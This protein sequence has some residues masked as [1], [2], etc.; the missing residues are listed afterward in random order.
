MKRTVFHLSITVT[1]CLVGCTQS[2]F[3][4]HALF[5]K[6]AME[7]RVVEQFTDALDEENEPALRRIT[8]SR[9]EEKA[10][11]SEDVLSDLRVLHLPSGKLSVVEVKEQGED[12]REVIVKE[13]SGGKY[14]FHLVRDPV[15]NYWV[16]DDVMVRQRNNGT[17]ITKST[18]EVM[19]LLV[20]LR[21]FL[22]VWESGSREEILAMTSSDLTDSLSPLP[23]D[24]LKALTNRIASSYEDG[25]ARKPEANLDEN[26]A[27]VK[28]PSKNGHILL[29]ITRESGLWLVDDVE[30]H[31]HRED[32]HPGSVRRQADAINAVNGFL[33]AYMAEDR[34][35]LQK[36][37]DSN[38]YSG[39]L[40]LAD[41]KLVKLPKPSEVPA[42]FD[43]RAFEDQ[44]TFMIPSGTEIIRL[45]LVENPDTGIPVVVTGAA[46]QEKR[47]SRFTV[48][49]VTLYERATQR[50]RSLSSV[51]TAPT[52]ASFFLK[53]LQ[54]RDH[55]MLSQIST[56]D[57][58]E[59]I[60]DRVSPKILTELP[61][62]NFYGTGLNLVDSH[63]VSDRTEIEFTTESGLLVSCKLLNQNGTLKV[64]DVQFPNSD[65]HVTSL[66]TRLEL[67]VPV[68][69]FATAWS[70]KDMELLQKSC[71]SDFN[72]L[73]WSHLDAVPER[74]TTITT[75]LK[76]PILDTRITQERATVRL[77]TSVDSAMTASLVM[78]HG[79][80]VIDEVQMAERPGQLVGIREKLRGEIADRLLSGSYS[81]LHSSDG[82]DVIVPMS[83][84]SPFSEGI[85]RVSAEMSSGNDE[86]AVKHAVFTREEYKD[87][88]FPAGTFVTPAVRTRNLSNG[89][90]ANASKSGQGAVMTAGFE[91]PVAA[92]TP[93]QRDAKPVR[94]AS[95]M[96][97]F[98]PQADE[99]ARALDEHA[100][101]ELRKPSSGVDM[102]PPSAAAATD[103]FMYFGPDQEKLAN[104]N[105]NPGPTAARRLTQPADMPI[106]I[107]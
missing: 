30:A 53:A 56:A 23:D 34:E 12:Q 49:D 21:H 31:N 10:L 25:M 13:E 50:Q 47:P 78:E 36:I 45:D 92:D 46:I 75:Q 52:R 26:D 27:V 107:D 89:H 3:S 57:F 80:W 55:R 19:D 48:K 74:F 59:G 7:Q 51:F 44:L 99:V 61:I 88:T 20:T 69:E 28:L 73:V 65:G 79:Y 96:Q 77:G 72:R 2:L 40:E 11:R 71:S 37:T 90:M 64:D 106:P 95:G 105:S 101:S 103:S 1:C 16:V 87:G 42:E 17:R 35:T 58:S 60:W 102:T 100:G 104:R 81:T 9:F 83:N 93:Q 24:W 18:T 67:A 43:I 29:K 33:T 6:T 82:H 86:S 62:P 66:R 76:Q 14:Q 85:Q 68:L 22:K 15:K 91:R 70:Q 39:S 8:S 97:V 32:N 84:A 4:S 41:L 94:S 38:F 54:Q 63:S 5:N 98:G